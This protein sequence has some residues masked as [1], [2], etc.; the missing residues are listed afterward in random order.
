MEGVPEDSLVKRLCLH[1]IFLHTAANL[2][3]SLTHGPSAR[4]VSFKGTRMQAT[5]PG[6]LA[7]HHVS[8][9]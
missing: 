7:E 8:S 9:N 5:Q 2:S 6:A 1:S 3:R 4:P